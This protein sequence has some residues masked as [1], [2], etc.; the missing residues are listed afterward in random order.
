MLSRGEI[1]MMER[2]WIK[3]FV[4]VWQTGASGSSWGPQPQL[5]GREFIFLCLPTPALADGSA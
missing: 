2:D 1:P 5:S 3:W 4:R